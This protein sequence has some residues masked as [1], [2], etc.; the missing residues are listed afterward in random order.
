MFS[1]LKREMMV[2]HV[3]FD[4]VV[5]TLSYQYGNVNLTIDIQTQ[6][7]L[8]FTLIRGKAKTHFHFYNFNEQLKLTVE[9]PP[10]YV[11]FLV[12]FASIINVPGLNFLMWPIMFTLYTTI[13]RWFQSSKLRQI[14]KF[15]QEGSPTSQPSIQQR[16]VTP[17][18]NQTKPS[19]SPEPVD[20]T[21]ITCVSCF[22]EMDYDSKF[23]TKCGTAV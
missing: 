3:S 23:C 8:K 15:I 7:E 17:N 18:S 1:L 9:K 4:K 14:A 12:G 13:I 19:P 11:Y 10:I 21:P 5:D 16:T 20:T 22:N 6:N 2:P